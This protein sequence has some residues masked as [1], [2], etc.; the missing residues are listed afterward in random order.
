MKKHT[1]HATL[2]I[3]LTMAAFSFAQNKPV[4]QPASTSSR[5]LMLMRIMQLKPETQGEWQDFVKGEYLPALKQAGITQLFTLRRATFGEAGQVLQITAIKD[6]AE[7]DGPNPLI[8]ALGQDGVNALMRKLPKFISDYRTLGIV[9]RPDLSIALPSGYAPK[10]LVQQIT[11]VTPG[12]TA[13]YEKYLKQQMV[14]AK[15]TSLKGVLVD[16]V[17]SGGDINEYH[18]FLFLDSFADMEKLSAEFAKAS[19]EAK[20]APMPAG[21]VT[22]TDR[23]TFRFVPELSI[24]PTAPMP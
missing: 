21:I 1:V 19:E 17:S 10:L 4:Q 13:D 11:S 12:R 5:Q 2:L 9:T 16:R 6:L 8:K 7:L 15:K 3:S 20:F 22:H 14:L 23:S 18:S 24:V